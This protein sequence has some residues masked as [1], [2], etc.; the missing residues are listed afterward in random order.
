MNKEK[1][2]IFYKVYTI[3]AKKINDIEDEQAE[4]Y[5][6]AIKYNYTLVLGDN[7]FHELIKKIKYLV[8]ILII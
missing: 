3:Q 2:H 1:R 8:K 6:K 4:A 7:N 5:N